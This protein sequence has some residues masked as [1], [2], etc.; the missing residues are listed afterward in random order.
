MLDRL[1]DIEVDEVA[2]LIDFVPGTDIVLGGLHHLAELREAFAGRAAV[3][4]SS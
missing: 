3:G 2:C 4:V 1:R